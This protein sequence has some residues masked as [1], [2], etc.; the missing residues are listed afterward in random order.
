MPW[1]NKSLK[2]D[3][4]WLDRGW[5]IDRVYKTI[6]ELRR[7]I[8]QELIPLFL[9]S[10]DSQRMSLASSVIILL[11]RIENFTKNTALDN[12]ANGNSN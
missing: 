10:G 6:E 2:G 8:C 11:D 4:K 12:F 3:R 1:G 9:K 7:K 5:N